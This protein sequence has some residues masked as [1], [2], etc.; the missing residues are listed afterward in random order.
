[1]SS[2]RAVAAAQGEDVADGVE[3]IEGP[4]RHFRLGDVLIELAIDAEA[5]DL[6][7]A[8]AVGVL[9]LLLEEF[10]G[11]F[12]LRRIAGPQPLVDLQKGFFMRRHF[13]IALGGLVFF[14]GSHDEHVEVL[15][16]LGF[17][18]Q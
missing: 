11:L 1:M 10:L 13:L 5:A 8:I 12:E 14:D 18:G 6:A 3:V 15:A 17:D 2:T 16:L 4:Q 9:E 7:Q